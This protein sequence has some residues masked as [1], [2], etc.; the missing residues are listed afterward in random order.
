MTEDK[1][2]IHIKGTGHAA[3]TPD[4]VVLSLTLTAQNKEYSAAM[5][6]GSQQVEMLRESIVEAGFDA[7]DL[8][9]INFDVR[10]VYEDEEYK[11]GNSK[12]YRRNFIGFECRHDLKLTFALDNDKLNAAVDT[13]AISLA[14][15]KISIAFTI[16]DA[17]AFTDEILKDAARNARRQAEI[18]CAASGVKLGKLLSVNY[19]WNELNIRHEPV[20]CG[21]L[22][23][24][25]EKNSFDFRPDEIKASD[26]V[27]F[28]WEI[29]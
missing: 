1:R 25:S 11:E 4:T 2:T 18:L 3:Q 9:T 6:I 27:D 5:K 13:I 22:L 24:P 20:P 15:P 28:I 29:E 10:A 21:A 17:D 12:R 26:S 7:D 14:Q 16:K 8:K 19:S 23:A